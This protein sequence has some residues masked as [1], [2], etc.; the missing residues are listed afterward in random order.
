MSPPKANWLF[1]VVVDKKGTTRFADTKAQ[2]DANV[3]LARQN[4]VL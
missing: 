1:F 3:A 2:H 4:G